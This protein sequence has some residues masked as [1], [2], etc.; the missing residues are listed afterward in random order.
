MSDL[1][2]KEVNDFL[3]ETDENLSRFVQK[4]NALVASIRSIDKTQD[5]PT[6]YML[7]MI[8]IAM[9]TAVGIFIGG[10]VVGRDATL[11]Q[12]CASTCPVPES[13]LRFPTG[14]Q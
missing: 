9:V 14:S 4:R 2:W 12:P 11:I 5:T 7:T 3:K 13:L 6:W 1:D 10:A 8:A